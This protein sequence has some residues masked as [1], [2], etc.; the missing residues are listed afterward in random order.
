MAKSQVGSSKKANT[1]QRGPCLTSSQ[2]YPSFDIRWN[3]FWATRTG[4]IET[5]TAVC[6]PFLVCVCI[7]NFYLWVLTIGSKIKF[8][9]WKLSL[10]RRRGPFSHPG[11]KTTWSLPV[12]L[13]LGSPVWVSVLRPRDDLQVWWFTRRTHQTVS[14]NTYSH[15][16]YSECIQMKINR[17]KGPMGRSPGETRLQLPVVCC[18]E[19]HMDSASFSQSFGSDGVWH[20]CKVL[21]TWEAPP[22]LRVQNF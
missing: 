10:K 12:P 16:Y 6:V 8:C 13:F 11:S 1:K 5:A 2:R 4:S 7:L 3:P 15:D 14:R 17:G 18:Q 22:S 21:P 19:N 9:D 20:V